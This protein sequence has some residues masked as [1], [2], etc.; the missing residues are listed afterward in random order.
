VHSILQNNH[1]G[2]LSKYEPPDITNCSLAMF[3]PDL[4]LFLFST[5]HGRFKITR[6]H[7]RDTMAAYGSSSLG[8][9]WEP[10]GSTVCVYL[11]NGSG[12]TFTEAHRLIPTVGDDIW[13]LARVRL[14]LIQKPALVGPMFRIA[15]SYLCSCSLPLGV[16]FKL[17]S[18]SLAFYLLY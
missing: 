12:L 6:Q 13:L 9:L 11:C 14:L 16:Q 7:G 17:I 15:R 10:L 2:V 4:P 1:L 3:N 18:K 5:V 8:C